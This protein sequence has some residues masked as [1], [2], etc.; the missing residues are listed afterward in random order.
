MALSKFGSAF[1]EARKAG[2]KEFTFNGKKYTTELADS[3]P[4]S[5][6]GTPKAGEYKTRAPYS[7][8][9][10][11]AIEKN[12]MRRDMYDRMNEIDKETQGDAMAMRYKPRRTPEALT[13]TNKPGTS[14][15]YENE[16]ATS[17]TFKKGGSVF[18]A[19]ANGIAQR[20]KTKGKMVKMNYGG[21]C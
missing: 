3:K 2:E 6:G 21:K 15:R 8:R 13:E 12:S 11:A 18:R 14:T 20:G 10:N 4:V 16:D 7:D 19:S 1:A 9:G 17:E 5:V